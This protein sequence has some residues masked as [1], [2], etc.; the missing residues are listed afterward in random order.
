MRPDKA[1]YVDWYMP[2]K[3]R[4]VLSRFKKPWEIA[5]IIR[6]A[7]FSKEINGLSPV[8]YCDPEIYEYYKETGLDKCFDEVRPVL[9]TEVDFDPS[10]FWSAGKFLAIRDIEESFFMVDLDAEVRFEIDFSGCDVF[11]SHIEGINDSDLIYY[12]NPEY[13]DPNRYFSRTYGITWDNK[14][15]NTSLLY[16]KDLNKAKEYANEALNFIA[17]IDKIDPAFERGYTLLAEQRYLYEFC[18]DQKMEVRTLISGLYK[19]E[20]K[21]RKTGCYFEDSNVDEIGQKGFLHIWGFKNKIHNL[22]EEEQ[23]IFGQL[24]SSRLNLKDHIIECVRKNRE[25]YGPETNNLQSSI[26]T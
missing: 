8:L 24:I 5:M 16:F 2:R 7:Y 17:S 13:L 14:A 23:I 26:D 1:L 9:P 15:Y 22:E 18:K 11:C 21:I 4:G 20:D 12:P 3:R 10:I 19:T 6:S 25:L